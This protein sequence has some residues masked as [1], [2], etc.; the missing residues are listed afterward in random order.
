MSRG[1]VLGFED[2]VLAIL[3]FAAAAL[4][5]SVGHAGASGYLAAM[6]LFELAP[7]TMRP[8]ALALNI[9]VGS[10]ALYRYA[11]VG[12]W[13]Y[14]ILLPFIIGSVPLAFVGGW[15]DVPPYLYRPAVGCLL[16]VSAFQFIRTA[17]RASQDDEASKPPKT[18]VALLS[19]GLLGL[20][21]GLT[22][23]GGGI[24]LSPLL[25]FMGWADTRKA[26]GLAAGFILANSIAGLLG[27]T[28]NYG[29]L[30]TALPL[31][32]AATLGGGVIG[33]SLGTRALPTPAI[34]LLLA[35]VLVVAG[36]KMIFS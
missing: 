16:L 25:L 30:P 4:Y 3:I 6:A 32:A 22:G 2:V 33:T 8:T 31:W 23:T 24:L 18:T 1:F 10:L 21:S 9:L 36:A 17:H 28:I 5:S 29:V 19:G 12:Q 11:K 13:D 14:R 7:E 20:I 34:R 15:I 27:T 35:A 26:S